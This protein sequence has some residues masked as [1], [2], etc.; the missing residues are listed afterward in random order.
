[1]P[2]YTV[3]GKVGWF[4]SIRRKKTRKEVLSQSWRVITLLDDMELKISEALF[5]EVI[6]L[7]ED[8]HSV[9][10]I[11][12]AIKRDPDEIFI[13]LFHAVRNGYKLK[14]FAKRVR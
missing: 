11:G 6:E 10:A 4:M 2:S 13:V 12:E 7:Y 9:E 1:M 3:E 5:Q 14:A 8:G